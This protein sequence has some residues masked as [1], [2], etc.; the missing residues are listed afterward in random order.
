MAAESPLAY[1]RISFNVVPFD[2]HSWRV[3]VTARLAGGRSSRGDVLLVPGKSP[4]ALLE[5][6]SEDVIG[7]RHEQLSTGARV[8][9]LTGRARGTN[10][11]NGAELRIRLCWS[12]DGARDG[13]S[14][15]PAGAS[16]S[17]PCLVLPDMLPTIVDVERPL[18]VAPPRRLP[19]IEY[20]ADLPDGLNAGGIAVPDW[21]GRATPQ[22]LQ[23]VV[24]RATPGAPDYDDLAVASANLA[25]D[26]GE[27][28]NAYEYS[29]R[30]LHDVRDSLLAPQTVRPVIC[31][32]DGTE[33][34]EVYPVAGAYCPTAAVD[35]GARQRNAGK[36]ISIARLLA[37]SW[38]G[39]GVRVWGENAALLCLGIG[40]ALGLCCVERMGE[41]AYVTRTLDAMREAI[42][43]ASGPHGWGPGDL[44][45]DMQL[46]LYEGLGDSRVR[47]ALGRL[48]R[49]HWGR[50]LPQEDLV[51]TLRGA[52]VRVPHVFE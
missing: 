32:V 25:H 23:S 9:R 35:V 13:P 29:R 51:A 36:P 28:A 33:S 12:P 5:V 34:S 16:F 2:E 50:F 45:R 1:D 41:A 37:Q 47:K 44:L 17:A 6:S 18:S 49:E 48:I 3:D 39:G 14:S 46:S 8:V 43:R 11:W 4:L 40:G 22:L 26:A 19:R 27:M 24:F 20:D 42:T 15:S 52:G 38:L 10:G 21:C 30:L 31:L 7:V